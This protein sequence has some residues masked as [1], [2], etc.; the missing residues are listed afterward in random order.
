MVLVPGSDVAGS[1]S[2]R[3]FIAASPWRPGDWA[4][5]DSC[6]H[7]CSASQREIHSPAVGRRR[8]I[9]YT[10]AQEARRGARRRFT[11]LRVSQGAA[12][13][14]SSGGGGGGASASIQRSVTRVEPLGRQTGSQRLEIRCA[15]F[16][17]SF[18]SDEPEAAAASGACFPWPSLTR[19]RRGC[20]CN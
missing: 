5:S 13:V 15:F 10:C 12:V 9:K 1:I 11:D 20:S 14:A 19:R 18:L 6:M 8:R 4:A 3:E 7:S 16:S 17:L 2:G